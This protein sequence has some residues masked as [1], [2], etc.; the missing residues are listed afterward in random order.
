MSTAIDRTDSFKDEKYLDPTPGAVDAI[1]EEID[2]VAERKLLRKLD[3]HIAPVMCMIFLLAYIDRSNIGNA[4]TAGLI[5]DC[6]LVGNEYNTVVT[7]FYVTY[8]AFEVPLTVL[9]KKFR[10]SRLI[11]G[12]VVGWG[13]VIVCTGFAN[14]YASLIVLRLLLGAFESGLFPCLALYL[15]S[16]YRRK[17]QAR[18]V[19]Y[20]F[21][22]SA[23]SGAFGGL[24]AYGILRI[25]GGGRKPWQ[26]LFIIEGIITVV[27]GLSIPWLLPDD[28]ESARYLTHADKELMRLRQRV[29]SIYVGNQ[30]FEWSKV[31]AAYS[32][33]KL[34]INCFAQFGS[35]VLSFGFST[36][37]P[38]IIRAFGFD[39]VTTQV[40]TVPIYFW[41]AAVYIT[42]S[43]ISDKI[44]RRIIFMIPLASVTL[45]GYI[46]L[47]IPSITSQ[48][49]RVF[50]LLLQATGI[51]SMVG[52][53]IV[54]LTNSQAPY[55][56]RAT[57]IGTQQMIGNCAGFV[58]G[59]IFLTTDAPRY[60]LGAKVSLAFTC[61]C[62]CLYLTQYLIFTRLN[63]KREKMSTEEKE[64]LIA[65]GADGDAHP[66]FRYPQ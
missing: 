26:W 54:L 13:I 46:I 43:I 48:G 39:V 27:F 38:N 16:F 64:R 7:L 11:T 44:G 32:D 31:R 35:N 24:L 36:F 57:A 23:L 66:D 47:I 29:E 51:Y 21:V 4:S 41:A 61:F 52:L 22:A 62:M 5:A 45:I 50:A 2:P 33:Y 65:E 1:A 18:R 17:E 28:F 10:P 53:N 9:L 8:V 19:A 14:S 63:A 20:L 60:Y 15:S 25:D 55:F 3:L 40:L 30:H 37:L 42:A 6:G 12:L 56:K 58:A 34:W 59:Q 49:V